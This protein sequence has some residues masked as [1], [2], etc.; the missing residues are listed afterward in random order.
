MVFQQTFNDHPYLCFALFIKIQTESTGRIYTQ[1]FKSSVFKTKC[2]LLANWYLVRVPLAVSTL[3]NNFSEVHQASF[4]TPPCKSIFSSW[5]SMYFPVHVIPYCLD[6]IQVWNLWRPIHDS[7]C[8]ISTFPLQTWIHCSSG[9]VET[10]DNNTWSLY[11][12]LNNRT[13]YW[14][15]Y[16]IQH[17]ISTRSNWLVPKLLLALFA[18]TIH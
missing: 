8:F 12:C 13:V 9:L 16:K 5:H 15:L 3:L 4:S 18:Q 10:I 14:L 1:N 7:E 6:Y 17:R 11:Y 2:L